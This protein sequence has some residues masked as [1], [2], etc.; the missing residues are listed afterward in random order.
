MARHGRD[1]HAT[2]N[3]C[4]CL[5]ASSNLT[6]RYGGVAALSGASFE[7]LDGEVHA[8]V[9][10]NGAGKSTLCR[11]MCGITA[12]DEGV[13]TLSGEPHRPRSRR[14][15][16]ERGVR[17]VMQELNLLP[18][19]TVAENIFIDSM[20]SRLGVIDYRAMNAAAQDAIAAVGLNAVRADQLVGS[21]GVGQQ[22]LVEIAAALSRKCRVLVLD[23]P[24]AALT[25]PEI[26]LL[27]TQIRR[28]KAAGVGIIYVSHRMEEIR[29]IT[30]RITV[31][32]DGK[33]IAT[34]PTSEITH[35]QTVKL[36]VGRDLSEVFGRVRG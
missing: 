8:L 6:K 20:P 11:I 14:E 13:M 16:E 33:W 34:H 23:E 18:T 21:L 15:A 19:L 7:L 36:M 10:E 4:L 29:A 26:E 30:D 12:P 28:L 3:P 27:F 31:L 35:E 32:R 1:G 9:G 22:Q 24:T 17:M 2:L 25:A 5:R